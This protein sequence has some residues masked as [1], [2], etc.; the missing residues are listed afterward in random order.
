MRQIKT[1]KVIFSVFQN[2]RPLDANLDNHESI[3]VSLRTNEI[4]F[5]EVSE[6]SYKGQKEKA[7]IL[8]ST[9][10]NKFSELKNIALS[11]ATD[12]NQESILLIEN[13]DSSSLV[14]LKNLNQESIGQWT[15]V[16]S[17]NGLDS[18]SVVNGRI[19]TIK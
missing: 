10:Y 18:Y 9:N 6:S 15:E 8:E 11:I 14:Y 16:S 17:V 13:D 4:D 3:K 19:Y 7:L 5:T 2:N 12:F 1:N